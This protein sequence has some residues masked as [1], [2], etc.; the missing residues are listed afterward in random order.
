MTASTHAT[1][2]VA[3]FER[4]A[5][6]TRRLLS[7]VP[8]DKFDWRPHEKS[9]T[10]G[11]VATH[12]AELPEWGVTIV[13]RGEQDMAKEKFEPVT[14]G[15]RRQLLEIF[16]SSRES[17]A[18]TLAGRSDGHLEEN[19]RLVMGDHV[20]FE[21]P[22]A[23]CLRDFVLSHITHHRAQLGVYLRLLDVPVPGTYGPTADDQGGMG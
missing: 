1:T 4:E 9:M 5:E 13:E 2:L 22:R 19:W 14:A 23:V 20:I 17:F 21:L 11:R 3:D 12:V 18:S 8:E 7:Q 15:D 10:L 6:I 16:D